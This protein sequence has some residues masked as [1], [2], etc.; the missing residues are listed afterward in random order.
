MDEDL[1]PPDYNDG[2]RAFLQALMARGT[3]TYREAKPI[4][5]SIL[6]AQQDGSPGQERVDPE[7]ISQETFAAYIAAAQEAVSHFDYEI[8]N[9]MH[10]VR[11]ERVYALVN[12][13][14]DPMT[15][16]ATLHTPDQIAFV[17]RVIDAM[18]EK[19]NTRR[20]EVMCVD[21]MQANKFRHAP[22]QDADNSMELDG[23]GQTQATQGTK[24]I[25]SSEVSDVLAAMVD[26]GWFERSQQGFYSLSP[27]ALLE[28]RAWL[29]DSYND[30]DL[31][32]DDWQRIK[33]CEA[34]KE[35][36]T[37]GQRCAERDCN[38]RIHDIC[39]D[40]FWRTR[41]QKTCPKCSTAWSGKHFVGSKAV[42]ETEA[43]KRGRRGSGR[44]RGS[45]M[46]DIMQDE[47]GEMDEEEE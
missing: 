47:D 19:Y 42:T 15:Q 21:S 17:K 1:I 24:G 14:S 20:M 32:P 28:L 8:R 27:R 38:V 40:A 45:L 30:P 7:T 36:V 12:T 4:V 10:Q 41:R 34:C 11:K 2:N 26:E 43:Y 23:E 9:A 13:T 39:E 35:I 22:R 6:T 25:K 5:A 16:L 18:F 33:F 46:E 29:T 37:V 31:G 44:D 3:L